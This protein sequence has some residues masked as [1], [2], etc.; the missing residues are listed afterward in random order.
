MHFLLA[1]SGVSAEIDAAQVPLLPGVRD[2]AERGLVAG[3]TRKNHAFLRDH[4]DWGALPDAEQLILADA[5]TSGGLLIAITEDR[6]SL[7][8]EELSR[9]A[10]GFWEIGRTM[11][12]PPGH[13]AV[14]GRVPG[15]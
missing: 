10:V 6:A 8:Q 9:R 15:E 3:G 2:L 14:R 12:G 5:Q 7:L 1:A 13:V 4:L 11:E